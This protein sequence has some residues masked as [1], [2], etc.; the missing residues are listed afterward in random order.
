MNELFQKD[1][2]TDLAKANRVLGA[3]PEIQRIKSLDALKDMRLVQTHVLANELIVAQYEVNGT[4]EITP[5]LRAKLI[6]AGVAGRHNVI[7][8]SLK[9]GYER[10]HLTYRGGRVQ[11]GI[12]IYESVK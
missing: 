1:L 10:I 4:P 8:T 9:E 6:K 11:V 2:E 3:T 7:G 5:H 12:D